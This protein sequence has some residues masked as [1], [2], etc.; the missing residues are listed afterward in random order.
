MYFPNVF[1]YVNGFQPRD[2]L[3]VFDWR[4]I[5]KSPA[6]PMPDEEQ[7]MTTLTGE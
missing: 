1:G 2:L 7:P 4:V 6:E 5:A 3:R